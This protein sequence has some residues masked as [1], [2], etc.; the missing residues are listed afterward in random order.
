MVRFDELKNLYPDSPNFAEVWKACKEHVTLDW[1]KW[2]DYMIQCGMFFKGSQLC[3]PGS[4]MRENLIK[5]KHSG[6]M[7]CNFGHNRTIAIVSEYYCC[8][9]LSQNVKKFVQSCRICQTTKGVNQN[10]GIYQPSPVPSK[11]WEDISMDFV[12]GFPRTQRGNDIVFVVVERFPKMVHFIPYHKTH[13]VMH[14]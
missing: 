8:P 3:I 10:T 2:L 14:I 7:A 1:S 12:L 4:S 11:T 13:D 5:E 6:G 9:Q